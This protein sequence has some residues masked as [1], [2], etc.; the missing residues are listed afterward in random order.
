MTNI[1]SVIEFILAV[2]VLAF[3]HE[4]GHYLTSVLFKIEVKEFGI[5][6]P[7]RAARLFQWRGTDFTLNW[8]PFGAFVLPKG[9]NDPA[10]PGGLAAAPPL[11]R[12]IVLIGGPLMN[13]LTGWFLFSLIF[14]QTGVPDSKV[15]KIDNVVAD[16]P[17]ERAGL[18][19]GD[20]V[21]QANG[22]S[23]LN[24]DQLRGIIKANAGKEITLL[25]N[26]ETGLREIH[27]VP[28]N[29]STG[30]GKLG[31][32]LTNPSI[33]VSWPE[34]I[35]IAGEV[36]ITYSRELFTLPVK[37]IMGQLSAEQSRLTSIVGLGNM[38]VQARNRDIE[39]EATS[40]GTPAV[41]ALSLLAIISVALGITNLLP[42]PALDGGR[43]IFLL[44]ELLFRKRIPPKYENATHL[45][46]FAFLMLLMVVVTIQDILVPVILP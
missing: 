35:P 22:Q 20:I 8:I 33:S 23:I 9:E 6:F 7:P 42:I 40:S 29:D 26:R 38:F 19:A 37:L 31:V 18:L 45:A 11:A 5:G 14:M 2:S 17:A 4:L 32:V 21:V 30:S 13:M 46:G 25:V 24:M 44:P 3:L 10:V 27:A 15:V 16:T 36:V 1:L 43:I 34:T 28:E 41:S 12:F 39:T